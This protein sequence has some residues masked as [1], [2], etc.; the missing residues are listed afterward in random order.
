MK[1]QLCSR[2]TIVAFVGLV[3]NNQSVGPVSREVT[4]GYYV[5]NKARQGSA[6][7]GSNPTEVP[8]FY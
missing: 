1:I 4:Q 8:R 5:G 7:M 2:L 3:L 6:G